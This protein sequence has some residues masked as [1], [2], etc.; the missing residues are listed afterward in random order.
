MSNKFLIDISKVLTSNIIV[1]LVGIVNGFIVPKFLGI[2]EYAALKTYSLYASYVGILH[3]GFIDGIYLKYGGFDTGTIRKEELKSE[4]LFLICIESI[5]VLLSCCVAIIIDDWILIAV[6]LVILPTNLITFFN[7]YYQAT[8]SFSKYAKINSVVPILKLIFVIFAISIIRVKRAEIFVAILVIIPVGISVALLIKQLF[9]FYGTSADKIFSIKNFQLIQIGVF[10]LAG[11]LA[12][13]LFFSMDRWF[14]KILLDTESFAMYAFAISM[15]SLIMIFV[16]SVAMVFYPMFVKMHTNELL[17]ENISK[18]VL[19]IGAI[20]IGGY[21]VLDFIVSKFLSEYVNSIIII[22]YLFLALPAIAVIKTLY[23]NL[24]KAKKIERFYAK[25]VLIMVIC[26]ILLNGVA[27]IIN[28]SNISIA[29]A[30]TIAFYIWLVASSN[31]FNGSE[32]KL[33]DLFFLGFIIIAFILVNRFMSNAVMELI[34]YEVIAISCCFGF[35]NENMK[36]L[37]RRQNN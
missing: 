22:Q 29:I 25:K 30:T 21:F 36:Y 34:I 19:S 2:G 35:Y 37:A 32:L 31:D 28:K 17:V 4:L 15:L 18:V 20:S 23:V 26:S 9:I 24:Y 27:V 14:I 7:F 3:L 6:S 1:L 10:I 33:K 12:T 13:T 8:G 16:N 5:I 11:N